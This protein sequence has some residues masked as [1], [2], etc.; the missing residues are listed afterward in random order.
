MSAEALEKIVARLIIRNADIV[1]F[2]SKNAWPKIDNA[3]DWR[4]NVWRVR[5][6]RI[7]VRG[8]ILKG[9]RNGIRG[10]R[11]QRGNGGCQ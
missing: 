5:K 8:L 2:Y 9:D 4:Y 3:Q 7:Q 6:G 10:R 1:S 11:E